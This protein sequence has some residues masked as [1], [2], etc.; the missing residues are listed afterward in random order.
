MRVGV[1]AGSGQAAMLHLKG[2]KAHMPKGQRL[3]IGI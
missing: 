3:A 1:H 2:R